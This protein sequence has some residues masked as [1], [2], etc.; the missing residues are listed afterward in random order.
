M[1]SQYTPPGTGSASLARTPRHPTQPKI[2]TQHFKPSS[3][4]PTFQPFQ[5]N[6][7]VQR[8]AILLDAWIH[9][10]QMFKPSG[11][12]H[13]H[14]H[15]TEILNKGASQLFSFPP[16]CF[17]CGRLPPKKILLWL[18]PQPKDGIGLGHLDKLHDLLFHL[19]P[20]PLLPRFESESEWQTASGRASNHPPNRAGKMGMWP[21]VDL[22]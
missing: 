21:K 8:A 16:V 11:K 6:P 4:K 5:P 15:P 12:Y 18:E 1:R 3:Q 13:K 10:D 14:T 22:L 19:L 20:L 9:T 7:A 2:G 17:F